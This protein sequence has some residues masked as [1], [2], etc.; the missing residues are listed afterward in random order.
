MHE[1]GHLG[2]VL[3]LDE[4]AQAE[5]GALLEE[6]TAVSE[7]A[8]AEDIGVARLVH[9]LG[10]EEEADLELIAADGGEPLAGYVTGDELD[11][12]EHGRDLA[13]GALVLVGEF[14]KGVPGNVA[15]GGPLALDRFLVEGEALVGPD[16]VL[17]LVGEALAVGV[18]AGGGAAQAGSHVAGQVLLRG[19]GANVDGVEREPLLGGLGRRGV[20]VEIEPGEVEFGGLGG[21]AHGVHPRREGC[22]FECTAAR[23]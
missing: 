13:H 12:G 9:D 15:R 8:L 5:A 1:H 10:H 4:V 19:V 18:L 16:I 6:P 3:G 22:A 7:G 17:G 2:E 14:L 23:S 21:C 20:V 11:L